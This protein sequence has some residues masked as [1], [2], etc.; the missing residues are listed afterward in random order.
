VTFPAGLAPVKVV[1]DASIAIK[2]VLSEPG[3]PH[4]LS[5]LRA[6]EGGDTDLLAPGLLLTEA[7]SALSKRARRR[8]L[9][10]AQ[11]HEAFRLLEARR[12]LLAD[13]SLYWRSALDLSVRHQ[14]SFWD[15]M[16][17]ALAIEH[18]CDLVTADA[19]F[20]RTAARHYP[21]VSLLK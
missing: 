12:P 3:T 19:R 16:Y 6:F 10:A 13:D 11:A 21:F 9:T 18:R 14:M 5:L 15:C 17:L 2:W 20:H 7:G 4:A 8:E 1:I